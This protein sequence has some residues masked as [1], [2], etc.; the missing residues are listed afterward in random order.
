LSPIFYFLDVSTPYLFP[1]HLPVW[2][3]QSVHEVPGRRVH[4]APVLSRRRQPTRPNKKTPR[5]LA[6]SVAGGEGFE[7]PH[8]DPESA[9]LPTRRAPSD[10]S[11]ILTRRARF[12]K[13]SRLRC[14][15][16]VGKRLAVQAPSAAS[17]GTRPNNGGAARGAAPA[18]TSAVRQSRILDGGLIQRSAARSHPPIRHNLRR[19]DSND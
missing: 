11:G 9:V 2:N 1:H 4:G 12:V 10:A 13:R 5:F 17:R 3:I 16:D 14:A 18:D 6:R 19:R 15:C 7:P 8:T